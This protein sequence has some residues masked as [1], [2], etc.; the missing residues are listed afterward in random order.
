MVFD[1]CVPCW[2]FYSSWSLC[3]SLFILL[4]AWTYEWSVRSSLDFK[5]HFIESLFHLVAYSGFLHSVNHPLHIEGHF[6]S[7]LVSNRHTNGEDDMY[8][9]KTWQNAWFKGFNCLANVNSSLN[10]VHKNRASK[11]NAQSHFFLK[12]INL[13]SFNNPI[14]FNIQKVSSQLSIKI[15]QVSTKNEE[16]K[17][18]KKLYID[19]ILSRTSNSWPSR[20]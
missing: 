10:W 9:P 6:G 1:C 11:I 12:K 14:F 5:D 20:V 4:K 8:H 13:D 19:V 17:R 16:S 3:S 18:I 7:K 15:E 2:L